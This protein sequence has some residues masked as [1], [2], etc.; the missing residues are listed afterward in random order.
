MDN[1]LPTA[2]VID[3]NNENVKILG[4]ILKR[5]G[6]NVLASLNGKD[7]IEI[8]SQ[9][10]S[11]Q[12]ILL[13]IQMPQMDGFEVCK[14]LK[15]SFE[16]RDIPIIFVTASNDDETIKKI[17]SLGAS[18]YTQ[19]PFSEVELLSRIKSHIKLA[20]TEM[21]MKDALTECYGSY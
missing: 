16:T 13:D 14:I 17:F 3:D 18:D 12:I 1:R 2:L 11:T 7:G 15:N 20:E 8:G 4:S 6:L 19:K 10:E 9:K 21:L 5:N